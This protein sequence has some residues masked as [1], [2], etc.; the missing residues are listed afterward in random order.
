MTSAGDRSWATRIVCS[1]EDAAGSAPGRPISRF[2]TRST[3]CTT[4]ERRSRRYGSSISS[5]CSTSTAICWVSAHSALQRCSTMIFF[6][7][8]ASVA[9]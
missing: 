4:S 2:S 5:N 1:S 3:T 9:S 8:S 6:G 7:T